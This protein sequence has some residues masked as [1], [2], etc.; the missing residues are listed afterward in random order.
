MKSSVMSTLT[1]LYQPSSGSLTPSSRQM[2]GIPQRSHSLFRKS[3]FSCCSRTRASACV[4]SKMVSVDPISTAFA[5][6]A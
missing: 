6:S 4:V 3:S 2:I 5:W 1:R